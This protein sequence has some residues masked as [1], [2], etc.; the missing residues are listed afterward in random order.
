MKQPNEAK[1]RKPFVFAVIGE[2][3]AGKSHFAS[4]LIDKEV[5]KGGKA[6]LLNT[7]YQDW[8]DKPWMH[9]LDPESYKY[10]KSCRRIISPN[11][12]QWLMISQNFKNGLLVA[13]ECKVY[14]PDKI[15]ALKPLQ[16]L[17]QRRRHYSVDMA[18]LAHGVTQ[19]PPGLMAFITH[20]VQF[21]TSD[22]LNLRK[23]VLGAW[24][25]LLRIGE[26]Y[27]KKNLK[28]NPYYHIIH[29]L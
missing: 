11:E 21:K 3:G 15:S 14:I 26:L 1:T 18:F 6:L 19:L 8:T 27:I 7:D 24:Y 17:L 16:T 13:D 2:P 9:G 20:F 5:E 10:S 4:G 29:E 28:K 22:S 25:P 23:T 12:D